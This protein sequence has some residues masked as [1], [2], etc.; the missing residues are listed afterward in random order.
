MAFLAT[1]LWTYK[2]NNAWLSFGIGLLACATVLMMTANCKEVRFLRLFAKYTTPIFLM[3]TL[4]AAPCRVLLMKLGTGS[5]A[6]HVCTGIAISF[7]GP[8]AAMMILERM[9]L[10]FLVYPGKLIKKRSKSG[11]RV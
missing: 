10:G 7:V 3:H 2:I 1:S 6:V 5:A 11:T 8:I 4:F 9:G